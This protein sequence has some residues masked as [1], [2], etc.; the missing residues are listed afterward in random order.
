MSEVLLSSAHGVLSKE[1][2]GDK[3]DRGSGD[4]TGGGVE[5]REYMI[6]ARSGAWKSASIIAFEY[7][8]N[9]S[10]GGK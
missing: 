8:P 6:I 4:S 10:I 9:V 3:G 7:L 5:T 1:G 2:D